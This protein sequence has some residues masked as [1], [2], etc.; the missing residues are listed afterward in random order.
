MRSG[1]TVIGAF[2]TASRANGGLESL[3]RIIEGLPRSPLTITQCEGPLVD[4]LRVKGKE[5]EVWPMAALRGSTSPA[6]RAALLA[7]RLGTMPSFNARSAALVR[8]RDVPVVLCN[9][10]SSMWHMGPGAKAAGARLVFTIRDMFPPETPYGPKW[11]LAMAMAD[12]TVVLSQSMRREALERIPGHGRARRVETIYS[13]VDGVSG[14]AASD[15]ERAAARRRLD[16]SGDAPLLVY[17]AG[18]NPKKNQLAFLERAVPA[19][20]ARESRTRVFFV[21]DHHPER[22]AYARSCEAAARAAD[23]SGERVRFVGFTRAVRDYYLAADITCLASRYEGLA[24]CMIESM[25]VGTPVVSFD[26]TSAREMLEERG[27][28]LVAALDDFPVLVDHLAALIHDPS[29]ARALGRRG[30]EV[31]G[32]LFRSEVAVR[33]YQALFDDLATGA[34]AAEGS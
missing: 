31:A 3:L 23:P 20:L 17:V 18:V 8:R 26:V 21:G 4:S 5:V 32:E 28:G 33:R 10:I 29:L 15:D 13:I 34:G 16:L 27:A 6:D 9:D 7:K 25:A 19:L 2:Q 1:P 30:A 12:V 11:S 14:V 22:D 24:R